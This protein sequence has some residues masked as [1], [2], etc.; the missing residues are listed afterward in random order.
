VPCQLEAEGPF[1]AE[2]IKWLPGYGDSDWA[3]PNG[4][5]D[6]PSHDEELSDAVPPR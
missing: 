2:V 4:D 6:G 5:P 1:R 3:G